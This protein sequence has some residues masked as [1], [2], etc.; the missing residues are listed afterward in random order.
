MPAPALA[1]VPPFLERKN[2]PVPLREGISVRC[3][4]DGSVVLHFEVEN[5][6]VVLDPGM[7]AALGLKLIRAPRSLAFQY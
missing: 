3:Q 6:A 5:F 2:S 1:V 4:S 7:A